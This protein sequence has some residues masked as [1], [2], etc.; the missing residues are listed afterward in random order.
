MGL[1][2]GAA[3]VEDNGPLAFNDDRAVVV[4]NDGGL[5]VDDEIAR[6]LVDVDVLGEDH[7]LVSVAEQC[8]HFLQ[9]HPLGL[10]QEEP[11]PRPAQAGDD[12]EDL[13]ER[14]VRMMAFKK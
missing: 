12:D 5:A 14:C 4:N 9:R 8:G 1:D 6:G 11:R 13:F 3:A 2:D 10:G 7:D